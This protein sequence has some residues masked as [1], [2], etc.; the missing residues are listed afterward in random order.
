V[1]TYFA[2]IERAPDNY[3]GFV[4]DVT[5]AAGIGESREAV[6]LSLS[7][8]LAL[9]LQDLRERGLPQ[10]TASDRAGLDLSKHEP[11]EPY[12]IVSVA[13]AALNPVSLEVERAI[14]SA[15]ITRAELARRMGIPRSTVS[16]ITDPFYFGHSV[17]TLQRV[18][19]ALNLQLDV[20]LA[21]V[22]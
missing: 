18:A 5:G 17:K 15:G 19:H 3:S 16:R 6:L 22:R 12:Q 9:S 10:P 4:P 14:A 20:S 7:Q 21:G 2:V 8:G 1:T 11:T 13:P